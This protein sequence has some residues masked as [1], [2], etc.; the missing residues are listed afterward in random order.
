MAAVTTSEDAAVY[1]AHVVP[2]YSSLF[3]RLLLAHVPERERLQVLDVGCGTGFPALDMLS[4]LGDGGRVI[5]IDPD[6]ALLDVARRRA[7]DAAGRRVFFK[8]ASAQEL[9]FGN[10]VFD[11]VTA[12]LS[13]GAWTHPE[14][15]LSELS[16][17]LVDGGLLLLTHALEGTFAE[18]FDMFREI[19]LARDDGALAARVD[20]VALR[21]P[22]P[23][24]LAAVIEGAGFSDVQV[25]TEEFHFPLTA[26]REILTDPALRFVVV[27]E[28]RW[29]AG[30]GA[31]D[32]AILDEVVDRLDTYFGRGPL[33]LTVR[34]GL[35]IARA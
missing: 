31:G 9:D 23:Q 10:Q 25:E 24:M 18:V 21:Y 22:S 11:V 1:D 4:R 13:F 28:W 14:R 35:V 6:S 7:L 29:I 8:V 16:R 3:G 26:A 5:A 19:S 33:S 30:F 20:R 34:A 12:N 32:E 2:R 17:V 15:A 27:P